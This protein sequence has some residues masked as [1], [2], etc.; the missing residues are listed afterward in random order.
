[1]QV[2]ISDHNLQDK[3]LCSNCACATTGTLTG[4]NWFLLDMCYV[5]REK[6]K[7]RYLTQS[8]YGAKPTWKTLPGIPDHKNDSLGNIIH[9][10]F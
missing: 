4:P 8:T 9:C 3:I 1:M 5:L 2:T 7:N 6:L 10:S